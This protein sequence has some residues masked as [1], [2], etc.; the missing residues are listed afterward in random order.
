MDA[1]KVW[2]ISIG[3]KILLLAL[4]HSYGYRVPF[5][6]CI[7]VTAADFIFRAIMIERRKCP[8]E[9]LEEPKSTASNNHPVE[10]EETATPSITDCT[11]A[12]G[13]T[14]I[15][16]TTANQS[17]S[18]NDDESATENLPREST[19]SIL[20][21]FHIPRVLVALM[22][23]FAFGIIFNVFEVTLFC[24]ITIW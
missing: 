19:F 10:G 7:V 14:K 9:W 23:Y 17:P 24:Y 13:S 3:F 15:E 12:H 4:F 11:T 8:K 1:D 6:L 20:Q 22:V 5:I 16:E 21:M 2:T 18:L